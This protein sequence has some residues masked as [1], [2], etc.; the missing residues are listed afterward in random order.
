MDFFLSRK[1][2]EIEFLKILRKKIENRRKNLD[3]RGENLD[4]FH[5]RPQGGGVVEKNPKSQKSVL[6]QLIS[7]S[8]RVCVKIWA[9]NSS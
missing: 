8:H 6:T 1:K 4:F 9:S 5:F 2:I 3:F 7:I